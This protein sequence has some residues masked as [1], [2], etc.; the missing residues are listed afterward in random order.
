M[1]KTYIAPETLEFQ[2]NTESLLT[3]ASVENLG[4][5]AEKETVGFSREG[6]GFGG[7][8]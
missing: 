4:G 5:E 6:R 7:D 2:L 8:E 3:S 1:K